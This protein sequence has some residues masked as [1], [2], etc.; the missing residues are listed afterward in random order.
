ME[1]DGSRSVETGRSITIQ[2]MARG[3]TCA[4]AFLVLYTAAIIFNSSLHWR[5]NHFDFGGGGGGGLV[6]HL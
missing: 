1:T 4:C 6:L 2:Y 5:R 3:I